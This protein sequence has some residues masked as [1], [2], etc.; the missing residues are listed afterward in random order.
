MPAWTK[1]KKIIVWILAGV[2]VVYTLAGF[3]VAPMVIRHIL[4]KTVSQ[5]LNR[6]VAVNSIRV[7]PYTL[8]VT[9]I[10]LSVSDDLTGHLLSLDQC[11][12]NAQLSSIFRWALV[13][14]SVTLG[15]PDIRIARTATDAFNFSDLAKPGTIPQD[16]SEPAKPLRVVLDQLNITDGRVQFEDRTLPFPF[17]TTISPLNVTLT[18]LDTAPQSEAAAFEFSTGTESAETVGLKGQFTLVPLAASAQIDIRAIDLGKYAPYYQPYWNAKIKKGRLDLSAT[19]H[20]TA[21]QAWV[22]EAVLKLADLEIHHADDDAPLLSIPDF[23]VLN[24]R[25]DLQEKSVELGRVNSQQA[26]IRVNREADGRLNW[27]TA[28]RAESPGTPPETSVQTTGMENE[29][30]D[31]AAT[32]PAGSGWTVFLSEMAM[33]NYRVEFTDR[34][35][36]SPAEFYLD[37]LNLSAQSLSTRVEE[38]GRVSLSF[39]WN[40]QGAV[41]IAGPLGLIPLQAALTVSAKNMDIRP[42]Q[43]YVSEYVG[44]VITSGHFNTQ[45]DLNLKI[46]AGASPELA[47]S[48][49]ASL[50]DFKSVDTDRNADFFNFRSIFLNGLQ[51]ATPP[52]SLS[53]DEVALTDF[54][55][56]VLIAADGTSNIGTILKTEEKTK[57]ASADSEKTTTQKSDEADPGTESTPAAPAIGIKTVTLQGGSVDFTDLNVKPSV[58]LPMEMLGGRISGLNAIEENKADVLLE[59][60]V[61]G[62]VPLKITGKINP[63]IKPPFVDIS[64][65]LTSVDLSPLTPYAEKYLG[66]EL[67]KGLLAMDLSYLVEDNKL[68]GQNK[69][70]LTQLTLGDSVP[71]P[72]ATKLPIK[73]AIALLKDRNGNIDI[74]LPVQGD[75]NDPEFSIGGIVLKML[76]NLILD[77]VTSPFKMLGALFGGGEELSHVDFEP[78]LAEI[79]VENQ[80]KLDNLAKALFERPGLNLEILGQV[81]PEGDT[82][83]LRKIHFEQQLK[84]AK[85]KAMMAG[86]KQAVPLEQITIDAE[87]KEPMIRQAYEA[88]SFPKPRDDKGREKELSPEEMEKMLNTA[89]EIDDDDLRH[90]AH[91]RALATKSYLMDAGNVEAQRLFVIE[92]ET[93]GVSD[94]AAAKSRVQFSLK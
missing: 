52:L 63:L 87:E 17:S 18:A 13:L 82:A 51:L 68:K 67:T 29:D 61:R 41:E 93:D 14:K 32:S 39:G 42:L 58:H 40:D 24:T 50:V 26:V 10:G 86:G 38:K 35:P 21:G 56:K 66:Y 76:G 36:A 94:G 22:K 69:A 70:V 43:P 28:L 2:L 83:G 60:K 48:G 33:D 81:D 9:L 85:L 23:Q 49:Q 46:P 78:G 20:W 30:A 31:A 89:I 80:A 15:A 8:S 59:G 57:A 19:A 55:N 7:N 45:G 25:I 75:L 16:S 74:D 34:Q 84:A 27:A 53:I 3:A 1:K 90:L 91:Q 64:L 65:N 62:N 79:S 77:I 88:A 54:Y 12:A 92:P 6:Q 37:K 71:S 11:Q 73:L 5:A 44:L 47:F 72:S 4:E